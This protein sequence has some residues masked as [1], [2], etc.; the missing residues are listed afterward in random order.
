MF[1]EAMNHV[2]GGGLGGNQAQMFKNGP[3]GNFFKG[4]QKDVNKSGQQPTGPPTLSQNVRVKLPENENV[5]DDMSDFDPNADLAEEE[6]ERI[7]IK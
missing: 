2:Q 5:A 1:D 4:K 6:I 7:K 3:K